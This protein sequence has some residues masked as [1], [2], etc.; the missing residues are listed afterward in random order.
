M[1]VSET[2][3]TAKEQNQHRPV[4]TTGE[5]ECDARSAARTVP[6]RP[7]TKKRVAQLPNYPSWPSS[8]RSDG[9]RTSFGKQAI[10]GFDSFV[11]AMYDDIVV[12]PCYR[13]I[14]HGRTAALRRLQITYSTYVLPVVC[15]QYVPFQ[16]SHDLKDPKERS[17]KSLHVCD[18]GMIFTY[19][20]YFS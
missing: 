8:F 7:Y 11:T 19:C 10:L 9:L 4:A 17:W 1:P 20:A 6:R 2:F 13:T 18:G 14:A 12:L 16:N 3:Y 5:N 15:T